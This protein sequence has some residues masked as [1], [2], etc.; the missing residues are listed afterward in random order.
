MT[1]SCVDRRDQT[2][3][4]NQMI[5]AGPTTNSDG[6]YTQAQ[7]DV[8][9]QEL[10]ENI[11]L[12][13]DKNPITIAANRYNNFYDVKD[14]LNTTFKGSND[15]TPYPALDNRWTRGNI[16]NLEFADFIEAFNYTPSGVQNQVPS[17]LLTDLNSYYT[18]GVSESI[19]GGFCNSMNS[20]F[21]Q[22]DAFYDLL[23]TVDGL[24][25]DAVAIINAIS[26]KFA[27]YEGILA[28]A[29]EEIVENL[30][31]EIGRKIAD[32]IEKIYQEIEDAIENF[33]I[34]G[35]IEDFVTDIDKRHTK[36]IMTVK[37]RLCN[38]LSDEN[39]EQM[40]KK[41]KSFIDYAIG[42]FENIDLEAV[43]MLVYRF[44]ALATNVE[45]LLKEIKNPLDSYGN[46][47]ER[48]VKR[49][50]TLS[51]ANTSTAI[52]NGAIRFSPEKR[53]EAI[54]RLTGIWEGDGGIPRVTP[55]G[56]NA[57]TVKKITAD[58]YKELPT[59]GAVFK[60]GG[61]G[62][63]K[64]EGEVFDEKE[65]LGRPA[66]SYVDLDVK[67][68]LL[69]LQKTYGSQFTIEKGWLSK[70]YVKENSEKYNNDDSHLSG[71]VIDIKNEFNNDIDLF[72]ER[73]FAAGFKHVVV[74]NKHI[75][76]DIRDIP[77]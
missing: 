48:V 10:A 33:D 64:V 73:A 3:L 14:Y 22:I 72:T 60:E 43:Q 18:G 49:L 42:L 32:A 19:L 11:K 27:S 24:I 28:F 63:W 53:Q 57:V 62:P 2:Y 75:H 35:Q 36:Y 65:G 69:R 17:K 12:Q 5:D 38:E 13:S 67:V 59:C 45:A 23:E 54:N 74:Y 55:T 76:L 4:N 40:K 21:N 15:L 30:I 9:A 77:R 1:S 46:R 66:Y 8:I 61:A 31:K 71:L 16:T 47:Y 44:C 7:I 39:K 26:T 6:S 41:V 51:N 29:Q 52:R 68:Y 37:E 20:L 34:L 25:N 70:E 56:A 50:Q 58:E